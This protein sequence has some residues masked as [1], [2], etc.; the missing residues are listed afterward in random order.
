MNIFKRLKIPLIFLKVLKFLGHSPKIL[1]FGKRLRREK[2]YAQRS[3]LISNRVALRPQTSTHTTK[4]IVVVRIDPSS[5]QIRGRNPI[6]LCTCRTARPTG[7]CNLFVGL[8]D[9]LQKPQ[10][11]CRN[12]REVTCRTA[13]PTGFCNLLFLCSPSMF[14]LQTSLSWRS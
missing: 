14:F 2:D 1:S 11:Y 12:L 6:A 3:E 8:A 9:S 7:F 4:M 5:W 13:R 10:W